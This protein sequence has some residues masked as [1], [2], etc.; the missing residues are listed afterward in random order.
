MNG[1]VED[2]DWSCVCRLSSGTVFR[3]GFDPFKTKQH[4]SRRRQA[5]QEFHS[6]QAAMQIGATL[7]WPS[8]RG[9][10]RRV[11][12]GLDWQIQNEYKAAPNA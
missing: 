3:L 9:C 5:P 11:V 7:A 2:K 4:A 6:T 8:G 12:D 10:G 1:A